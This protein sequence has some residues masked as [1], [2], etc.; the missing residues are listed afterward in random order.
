MALAVLCLLKTLLNSV[1]VESGLRAG[2][3]KDA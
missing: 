3:G 1:R 2:Q